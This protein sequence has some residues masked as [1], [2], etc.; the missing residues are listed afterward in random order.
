MGLSRRKFLTLS[1]LGLGA[2][3]LAT[4]FA[5]ADTNFANYIVEKPILRVP[6]LPPLF[7]G[8][9]IGLLADIHLGRFL[10]SEVVEAAVKTLKD[11]KVDILLLGGDYIW[12]PDKSS[13]D[14]LY[15]VRNPEFTNAYGYSGA[16]HIFERLADLLSVIDPPDGKSAV[17]GN[18]DNWT[19]PHLCKKS[20]SLKN[21]KILDNDVTTIWRDNQFIRIFG[22]ADYWTD[23][24]KISEVGDQKFGYE[25]RI[26]LAHNPD[27]ISELLKHNKAHFD[28]SIH[29]HTHGGQVR[30]PLL[31]ALYYNIE[32]LRFSAGS[33]QSGEL[34]SY[35]SRG[36]GM[37]EVPFRLNC[38]PEVS[39]IELRKA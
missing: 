39:I 20:F 29:G 23:T 37:V 13:V 11:E 17:L 9:R 4:G 8:Y 5:T 25:A 3:G 27:Y 19:G 34:I 12:L 1:G 10:P 16:E 15:P 32:D 30:F 31:G 33:V 28:V 24:P 35:V 14:S 22:A 38:P 21:I 26:L 7:E 2:L 6:N 18:H 36:L